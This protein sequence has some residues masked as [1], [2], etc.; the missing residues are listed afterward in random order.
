MGYSTKKVMEDAA[1]IDYVWHENPDIVIETTTLEKFDAEI[2]S[3]K[4]K[5][6]TIKNRLQE[7][8]GLQDDYYDQIINLRPVITRFRSYIR[9]KFGPNSKQFEQTGCKRSSERKPAHRKPAPTTP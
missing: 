8:K 9:G 5:E 6:E 2:D 7:L 3:I 1:Q 4:A